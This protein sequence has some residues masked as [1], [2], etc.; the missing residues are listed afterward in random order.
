[1]IQVEI[2]LAVAW[3]M[4]MSILETN[5]DIKNGVASIVDIEWQKQRNVL[6]QKEV[7]LTEMKER[8]KTRLWKGD[9]IKGP[10]D[11]GIEIFIFS[12][13]RNRKKCS[14]ELNL[15]DDYSS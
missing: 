14:V 15:A 10:K 1:M 4:M 9:V 6:L 5:R 11:R 13:K 7:I 2:D 12:L 3:L 8:D